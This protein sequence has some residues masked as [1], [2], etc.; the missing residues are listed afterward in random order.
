MPI[1]EEIVD[2]R[3]DLVFEYLGVVHSAE[4]SGVSPVS[5]IGRFTSEPRSIRN[6]QSRQCPWKQAPVNPRLSP[7]ESTFA[8][9]ASRNFIALT[10]P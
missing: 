3:T 9:L 4:C 6:L 7:R 10:S 5:A 8:P 1:L 2:G